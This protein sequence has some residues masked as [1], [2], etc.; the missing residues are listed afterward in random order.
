MEHRGCDGSCECE[1]PRRTARG[2]RLLLTHVLSLR[3]DRHIS[4]SF[5]TI[6]ISLSIVFFSYLFVALFLSFYDFVLSLS[7]VVC[8]SSIFFLPVP[9]IRRWV[10]FPIFPPISFHFTST[11]CFRSYIFAPVV[12]C[13]P[14]L[15]F[16]KHKKH[17]L[18]ASLNTLKPK[19][20]EI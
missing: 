20:V 12:L 11:L 7:F 14:F 9:Y 19:L 1:S 6:Y 3:R 15:S 8:K 2:A 13:S 16:I 18:M 10:F 4:L 5:L 17:C